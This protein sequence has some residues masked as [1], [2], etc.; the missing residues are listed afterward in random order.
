MREVVWWIKC[1]ELCAATTYR[2]H[3]VYTV[4][5][6]QWK[7]Q[8]LTELLH[9]VAAQ[10]CTWPAQTQVPPRW[11]DQGQPICLHVDGLGIFDETSARH[12]SLLK[13][14]KPATVGR[15]DGG[16]DAES[17]LKPSFVGECPAVRSRWEE[18]NPCI[19]DMGSLFNGTFL[20]TNFK[21]LEIQINKNW[22]NKIN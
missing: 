8:T 10:S 7:D 16:L 20:K 6:C 18:L 22:C 17:F 4:P 11:S 12:V 19:L 15:L 14:P 13:L 21:D 3:N 1:L 5:P 9:M 2:R